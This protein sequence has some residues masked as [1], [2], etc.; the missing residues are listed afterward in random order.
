M[1]QIEDDDWWQINKSD[2]VKDDC[3]FSSFPSLDLHYANCYNNWNRNGDAYHEVHCLPQSSTNEA[4]TTTITNQYGNI[5]NDNEM[6]SL[7]SINMPLEA[8]EEEQNLASNHFDGKIDLN[9]S[10]PNGML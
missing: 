7:N 3:L 2:F 4:I 6:I 1:D 9:N 5:I 8:M 10:Y